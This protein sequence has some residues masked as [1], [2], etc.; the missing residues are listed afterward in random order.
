MIILNISSKAT[1]PIV[2]KFHIEPP[3]PEG[4]KVCSNS[5]SRMTNMDI[6]PVYGKK[7]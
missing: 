1:W 2:T 6:M 5:P 4:R 7:F 3:W